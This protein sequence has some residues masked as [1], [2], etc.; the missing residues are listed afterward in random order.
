VLFHIHRENLEAHARKFA[1]LGF[2]TADK[3]VPLTEDSPTL[4]LLFQF[5]Y[6]QPPPE[7]K[8]VPFNTIAT[9]AEAAEKYE[10]FFAIYV[11][12]VH[13]RY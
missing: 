11:C 10:V 13:F 7:L 6:P 8:V 4:E 3:V 1:L 5:M 9:L 12:Q 2:K